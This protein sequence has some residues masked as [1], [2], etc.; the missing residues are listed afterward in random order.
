M[1][2]LS[3]LMIL[4][5]LTACS[6]DQK[7]D[8]KAINKRLLSGDFEMYNH[9]ERCHCDSLIIDSLN[10]YFENDSLYTGECFLTY[11][12][13]TNFYEIRQLFKGQLHG[14]RIIFSPKG[15][16]LN[17]NIYNFGKLIR[18][19]VGENEICHCDSLEEAAKLNGDKIMHYFGAPYNGICQRFFPAPDTNKVYLEIPYDSGKIHGEMMIYNRQGK[20]IL[21]EKYTE[22]EKI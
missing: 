14:N 13:S 1:K 6:S 10:I 12:N 4:A 11:P 2:L 18:R 7:P 21:K 19:S 5:A 3:I 16:T 22:G 15:D 17:Q 9:L 20:V 8:T